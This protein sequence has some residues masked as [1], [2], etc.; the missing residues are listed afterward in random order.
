[1]NSINTKNINNKYKNVDNCNDDNWEEYNQIS[2]N[3]CVQLMKY[4]RYQNQKK[5]KKIQFECVD[6]NLCKNNKLSSS[7]IIIINYYH[8]KLSSS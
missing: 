8:H 7:I 1:M 3:L 4:K 2:T 5:K 6:D